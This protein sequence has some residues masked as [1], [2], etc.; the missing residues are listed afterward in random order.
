VQVVDG[1]VAITWSVH[2]DAGQFLADI[3]DHVAL[4]DVTRTSY[5][6]RDASAE[7]FESV[8]IATL[9]RMGGSFPVIALMRRKF[10]LSLAD[11]R[12]QSDRIR[13]E[14]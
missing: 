8:A 12:A 9:A 13:Q 1:A 4:S 14:R 3:A 11:A 7:E 10:G 6:W 2:P 5:N